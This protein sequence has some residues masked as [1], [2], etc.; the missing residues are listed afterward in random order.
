MNLPEPSRTVDKRLV[1]IDAGLDSVQT[2]VTGVRPGAEVL[3]LDPQQ[4]GLEQ[5]TA[6]LA[7]SP[8]SSL[9]IVSHG[10]P[11]TLRLGNSE[12]SLGNL[13]RYGPLLQTWKVREIL[14]YGCQVAAGDAGAEFLERLQRLTG[15]A[16]AA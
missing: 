5:I 11:A 3:L 15:A 4:D 12:L 7:E 8:F 9:H 16:I 13:A 10:A 1:V 2:L 14:L 6:A